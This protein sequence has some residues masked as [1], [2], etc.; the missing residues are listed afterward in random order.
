MITPQS[1]HVYPCSSA[2]LDRT[3]MSRFVDV[4]IVRAGAK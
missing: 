2:P 1:C 3:V 4:T